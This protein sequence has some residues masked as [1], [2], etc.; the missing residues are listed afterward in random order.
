MYESPNSCQIECHIDCVLA[1][2]MAFAFYLYN[3]IDPFPLFAMSLHTEGIKM[4]G[5]SR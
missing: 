3:V 5:V 4:A 1:G 2:G